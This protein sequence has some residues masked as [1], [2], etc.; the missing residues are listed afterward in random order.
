MN[1][2]GLIRAYRDAVL[3]KYPPTWAYPEAIPDCGRDTLA[4][5][6][7][8]LDFK[9]GV[10][11]GVERGNYSEVL[12]RHNPQALA[13]YGV[14]PWEKYGEYREHVSQP[15]L[16]AFFTDTCARMHP[17]PNW[18]PMRAYSVDAAE[19]FT[20]GELDF[21]YIDGN[22]DFIHVAQDL[23]AWTPKVRKG[24]IIAGHDY[25]HRRFTPGEYTCQVVEV[26]HA[27]TSA[28]Q[29]TPWFVLGSKAIVEGEVRDRPRSYMWVQR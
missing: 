8:E 17:Y 26:V 10:E 14:D 15:K 9:R 28:H 23:H 4:M 7:H 22:H 2:D 1:L 12:C 20:D 18:V 27:W 6:F 24:G 21:V 19:K 25:I 5:L 16:D 13:I 11:V 3:D 29:I